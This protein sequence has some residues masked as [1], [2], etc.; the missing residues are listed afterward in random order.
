MCRRK[1]YFLLLQAAS[2][3]GCSTL[4][5]YPRKSTAGTFSL[6]QQDKVDLSS[7]VRQGPAAL[8]LMLHRVRLTGT[9]EGQ[10][11]SITQVADLQEVMPLA[12]MLWIGTLYLEAV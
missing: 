6:E 8:W 5:N 12:F 9:D 7:G 1:F 11:W 2:S 4:Q 10:F 3:S